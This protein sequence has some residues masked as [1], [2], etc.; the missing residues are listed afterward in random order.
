MSG[1]QTLKLNVPGSNRKQT[2]NAGAIGPELSVSFQ[3]QCQELYEEKKQMLSQLRE[4]GQLRENCHQ[5]T[6]HELQLMKEFK[7][8]SKTV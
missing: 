5:P 1:E 7:F 4:F 2:R 8:D 6:M 3:R